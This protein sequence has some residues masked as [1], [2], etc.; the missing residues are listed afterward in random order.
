M[1]LARRLR[2]RAAGLSITVGASALLAATAAAKAEGETP[3]DPFI[4]DMVARRPPRRGP[5][6]IQ[7]ERF[8][9]AHQLQER[10]EAVAASA[11]NDNDHEP[12]PP[13]PYELQRMQLAAHKIQLKAVQSVEKKI[14]LK[15]TLLPLYATWIEGVLGAAADAGQAV[16]DEVIASMLVWA[17][18]CADWDLAYRIA[19]HLVRFGLGMP[20][21][22][23]RDLS[24]FLA[25]ETA[26]AALK[27]YSSGLPF[28]LTVIELFAEL[29][30]GKDMPD[31][32][33][34]RLVKA[35]A[36]GRVKDLE[37]MDAADNQVAGGRAA[38]MAAAVEMFKRALALDERCGV[39]TEIARLE[40]LMQKEA[41]SV[42]S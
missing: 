1:S 41:A 22:F 7:R 5:A 38:A 11:A 36:V 2:D 4:R 18:D 32:V 23:K 30:D 10:I 24:T 13:G 25:E 14:E 19:G 21:A 29:V 20:Q 17:F 28:D 35:Q 42:A 12:T 27:A 3:S 16:H 39:K 8:E 15:K 9:A 34:A 6:R 40:K 26:D 37:A 31:E 33:K